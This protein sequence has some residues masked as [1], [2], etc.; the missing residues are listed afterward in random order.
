[1]SHH[2][3][4]DRISKKRVVYTLPD[5][6][7]V[8]VRRDQP[9]RATGADALMD[10]YY[11][12]DSKTGA[13]TAAVVFVTGFSD[14]GAQKAIG[15]KQKEM[16]SYVSWAQ[17]AAASGLVAITYTNTEPATDVQAVLQH[18]RQ[19]AAA[20]A[21]DENR[22][23]VWACSGSVPTVLSV[24]MQATRDR[25]KCAVLCY[26][27][28][29]DADGSTSVADA[30][31][32]WGFASPCAGKSVDDLS[33]DIPLFIARAGQD[34]MPGLNDTLDRFLFKTLACNLPITFVN[35]A[36]APH[37]FDLFHDTDTTR[38]VIRRIL[39]FLRF[40]LLD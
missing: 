29:L 3:Q 7:V 38:E 40:H 30:A 1:M 4:P 12:P 22:I 36:T 34:Q 26:G 2:S 17:L 16:G 15:C 18:I 21:I 5:V 37:A 35:H 19:N 28:T 11:P 32:Q 6:E 13:P 9:Y 23:G 8:T 14:D 31:R 25:V 27:Y 39:A 10:L 24:L 33:Q 20:L